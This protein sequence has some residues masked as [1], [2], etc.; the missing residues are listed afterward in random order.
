[1]KEKGKKGKEKRT[2]KRRE[3]LDPCQ[4][5]SAAMHKVRAHPEIWY[6]PDYQP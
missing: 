1:M 5:P 6:K 3:C 4:Q 2:E